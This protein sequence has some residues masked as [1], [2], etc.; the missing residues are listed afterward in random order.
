MDFLGLTNPQWIDLGISLLFSVAVVVLGRRIVDLLMGP[1]AS[2]L[3]QR[4][5]T[6]LDDAGT[7]RLRAMQQALQEKRGV[8]RRL[9]RGEA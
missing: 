7:A 4:T 8:Y 5:S 6:T 1:V 2:R 3:A 9:R